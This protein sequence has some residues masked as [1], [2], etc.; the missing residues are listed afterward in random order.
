MSGRNFQPWEGG[1]GQA[2]GQYVRSR[3][4]LGRIALADGEAAAAL[5]HFLSAAAVP[6]NLGEARH[7]LANQAD[8]QYWLGCAGPPWAKSPPPGNI[9]WRPPIPRATSRR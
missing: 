3:L 9:G 4:T 1:E 6:Q 5:A 7:L 2:L 8:V